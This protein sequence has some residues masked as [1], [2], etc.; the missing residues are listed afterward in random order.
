MKLAVG[1][2]WN[3]DLPLLGGRLRFYRSGFLAFA[4]VVPKVEFGMEKKVEAVL[5]SDD[6][7][8]AVVLEEGEGHD[9]S[10]D[11]A[12]HGKREE[13]R[14]DAEDEVAGPSAAGEVDELPERERA[15]YLVLYFDELWDL[16]LHS[17]QPART[18]DVVQSGGRRAVSVE[19]NT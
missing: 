13:K 6:K 9:E 10:H 7:R 16:E 8:P 17:E 15:E 11:D 5:Y 4:L 3:I 2:L 18:T 14:E 12:H 19:I 1:K